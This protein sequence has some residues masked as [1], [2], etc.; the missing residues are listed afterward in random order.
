MAQV[1]RESMVKLNRYA[2][3]P[4]SPPQ[5]L[6]QDDPE[7]AYITI[8]QDPRYKR[9]YQ[10]LAPGWDGRS[11][12]Q[13]TKNYIDPSHIPVFGVFVRF[14]RIGHR[15]RARETLENLV[16]NSEARGHNDEV[17]TALKNM[18]MGAKVERIKETA[19]AIVSVLFIFF[20]INSVVPVDAAVG[21]V[22]GMGARLGVKLGT[23]AAMH[24]VERDKLDEKREKASAEIDKVRESRVELDELSKKEKKRAEI[25]ETDLV[26]NHSDQVVDAWGEVRAFLV[27]LGLPQDDDEIYSLWEPSR[28]RLKALY[29]GAPNRDFW[30]EKENKAAEETVR[31]IT[32]G[33]LDVK[34][35]DIPLIDLL[36]HL[37]DC[38][39]LPYYHRVLEKPN[40][41]KKERKGDEKYYRR[42]LNKADPRAVLLEKCHL[43]MVANIL[44]QPNNLFGVGSPVWNQTFESQTGNG[45]KDLEKNKEYMLWFAKIY[46]KHFMKKQEVW[47]FVDN[48]DDNRLV[49][50]LLWEPIENKLPKLDSILLKKKASGSMKFG[51]SNYKNFSEALKLPKRLRKKVITDAKTA[52]VVHCLCMNQS[53]PA[54]QM[55]SEAK[56]LTSAVLDINT[57]ASYAFIHKGSTSVKYLTNYG[58]TSETDQEYPD[59]DW[60]RRGRG[61]GEHRPAGAWPRSQ[62]PHRQRRRSL[63]RDLGRSGPRQ[64][65]QA[66]RWCLGRVGR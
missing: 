50:V 60:R 51:I 13:R 20:P 30:A 2:A 47:G 24:K 41:K 63:L 17:V 11:L 28:L 18:Q 44:T 23:D 14:H 42:V 58:F 9:F 52:G 33:E 27:Y 25:E 64:R 66:G 10:I 65:H 31:K 34:T 54:S 29:G 7:H 39:S 32:R 15:E 53:L 16:E 6:D 21:E 8:Q 3:N 59:R 55:K 22:A 35:I 48:E 37:F 26:K 45:E 57:E 43:N 38:S 49:G 56:L 12:I 19:A 61:M 1:P 36:W 5:I 40:R 62:P 46:I 4:T